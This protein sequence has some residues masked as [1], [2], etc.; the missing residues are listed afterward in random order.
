MHEEMTRSWRAPFSGRNRPSASSVLTT[1]DSGAAQ[2]YVEIPQVERAI[3][4]QLCPQ[5]AA[6]WRDNPHHPSRAF[7]FSSALTAKAY[8]AAGQAATALHVMVLLQ[9]HQPKELKQLHEG[10]ADPGVLQ[11]LR[12]ARTSPYERRKSQR[13][14]WVR[15]CPH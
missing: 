9:V 7:K 14:P 1:I 2:G 13:G 15:R 6:A 12:T 11:K 5:G 10:G 4:M 3:A 8:G